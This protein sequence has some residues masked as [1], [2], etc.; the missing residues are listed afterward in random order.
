MSRAIVTFCWAGGREYAPAHV[1]TLALMCAE[2]A[3]DCRFVCVT[4]GFP[5]DAFGPLVHVVPTPPLALELA[6]IPSPEGPI[7]PSSYRRV[8]ALSE[9]ACAL[10]RWI[11]VLDVDCLIVGPLA[12]YFEQ[13]EAAGLPFIGWRP[14][15]LWGNRHR[16]AGGTWL[17][18]TGTLAHLWTA[19]I[20]DP[21]RAIA[22]ARAA[23]YRGSDQALLSAWLGPSVPVLTEPC[24]IYQGQDHQRKPWQVPRDA[25]IIHFNGQR[26]KPWDLAVRLPW[27]RD[28]WTPYAEA[29][30]RC[31]SR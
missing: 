17:H 18:R 4:D 28:K 8:W 16:I 20:A 3:P 2:H 9:D 14:R 31:L 27:V 26:L 24:G 5:A 23:D 11:M 1:N 15:S 22:A 12:R 6:A 19:F 21:A 10:A 30:A 13:L 7:F 25:R 29:A